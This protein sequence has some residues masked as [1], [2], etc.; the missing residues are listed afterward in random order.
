MMSQLRNAAI[1]KEGRECVIVVVNKSWECDPIMGVLLSPVAAPLG[2]IG[3]P[4]KLDHPR[5]PADPPFCTV[6]PINQTGLIFD[7]LLNIVVTGM[8]AIIGV[9][10]KRWPR[11][12]AHF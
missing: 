10:V 11:K 4:A 1:A 5:R 2:S 6:A 7:D 9:N 8:I 12:K 3:W